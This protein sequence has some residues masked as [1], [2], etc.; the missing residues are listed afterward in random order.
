MRDSRIVRIGVTGHFA[1][2]KTTFIRTISK[3]PVVSV[4]NVLADYPDV[5]FDLG[6]LV[7]EGGLELHLYG[8]P[9]NFPPSVL[10]QRKQSDW[11]GLVVMVKSYDDRVFCEV[12][13]LISVLRSSDR[14]CRVVAANYQDHPAAKSPGALRVILQVPDDVPLLP[15]VATDKEA[16]KRVLLTL[17]HRIRYV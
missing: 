17:L 12:Q 8:N 2:G 13:N 7:I 1:S 3:T 11:A 10:L 16:V 4:T 9:S 15:C 14:Y 6:K 5:S